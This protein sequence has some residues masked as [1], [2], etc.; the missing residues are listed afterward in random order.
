MGGITIK[1][2]YEIV[3]DKEHRYS[4]DMVLVKLKRLIYGLDAYPGNLKVTIEVED[5]EV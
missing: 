4:T 5:D 3:I 1:V 2:G